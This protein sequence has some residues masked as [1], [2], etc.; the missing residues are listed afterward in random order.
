MNS[1]Q[2]K[3]NNLTEK[4]KYMEHS[5]AYIFIAISLLIAYVLFAIFQ[6][7]YLIPILALITGLLTTLFLDLCASFITESR[8]K[9]TIILMLFGVVICIALLLISYTNVTKGIPPELNLYVA[10]GPVLGG[11]LW[12]TFLHIC[13]KLNI[14]L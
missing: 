8:S 3:L 6:D 13:K 9:N 7:V 10:F 5:C 12:S 4:K 11:S 1:K 14:E 2:I